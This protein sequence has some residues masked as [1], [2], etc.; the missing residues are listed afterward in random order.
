MNDREM[1]QSNLLVLSSRDIRES[2]KRVDRAVE[3]VKKGNLFTKADFQKALRKVSQRTAKAKPS[4][5][6][7]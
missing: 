2:R 3:L 4:S 5:K 1:V 7:S 6:S